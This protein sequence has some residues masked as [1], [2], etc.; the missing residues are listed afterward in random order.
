MIKKTAMGNYN[1]IPKMIIT[2]EILKMIYLMEKGYILLKTMMY[3]KVI[4]LM[5]KS[6]DMEFYI[7]PMEG[8]MKEI[9]KMGYEM[10]MGF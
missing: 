3:I 1:I 10:D 7:I 9:L 8:Y 4:F 2:K 5:E 6:A